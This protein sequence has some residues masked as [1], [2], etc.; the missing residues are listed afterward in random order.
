DHQSK[1]YGDGDPALTYSAD[2]LAFG[3]AF[4]GGLARAAGESVGDY[5]IGQGDLA[6]GSNYVLAF[7]G[8]TLSIGTR[9]IAVAADHPSKTYGDGDP[10]LTYSADALAFGDAF[11]GGLARAAGESVGDYAIGQ[12]DLALGSNYVLAFSGDTLSIGPR[13]TAVAADHQ[14]KTYGDGD[15]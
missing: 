15:P 8:D 2:A 4:T 12:G 1:T 13:T 7:S 6:L 3:D 14:S 5:A 9:T 10:A 11:T